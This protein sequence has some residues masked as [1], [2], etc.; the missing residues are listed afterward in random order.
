MKY[1]LDNGMSSFQ[2]FRALCNMRICYAGVLIE[3]WEESY[4]TRSITYET[5]QKQV[6][7]WTNV[8]QYWKKKLEEFH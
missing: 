3:C 6:L 5:M 8:K 7:F 1:E 4:D 2:T